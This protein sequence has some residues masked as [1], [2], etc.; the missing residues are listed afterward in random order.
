MS[1]LDVVRR[2]RVHLQEQGRV[3]LRALR[4]EFDLDD[5]AL[6]ELV[7]ELVEVQRVA[8]REGTTVLVH[9]GEPPRPA[10]PPPHLADKIRQAKPAVEGERKQVTVLF[11]DVKGSM[12]LAEQLDPEAWSAIMQRFFAI[13]A[14]GV[15]RFEGFVDKFTGD[16]IMALFGA[17]IA[18]EDHAQ[19]ACWAALHLR[20]EI[21]RYATE[22]KREHGIGFSTR[23]GINSGEV[24]LGTI[25][26]D[27]RMSYT[28]QGHTVGLAQRMEAL[29]SAETCYVSAAT[30]ALVGGY[31]QLEDLGDFRVKGASEPVRVHRLVGAGTATTRLDV[32]RARGLTRF[33]GRDAD[34]ATLEAALAQAQAGHG[35]VV[36]IVAAA[37]TGKSRLCWEFAERCR[38]RGITVNEG[39]A[40][41]HGKN[42]PY[43]PMLQLFRAYYGITDRDDDATVRDKIAGRLLLLDEGFRDV[44]PV[45][46]EF[47]RVPDPERPVPRMDPEA[48][49]RQLFAV[50]RRVIQDRRV[51][52]DRVF[53]LIEDLHW[54][55]P[56]SEALLAQWIDAIGGSSGLLLVNFRPE[57]HAEW[58]QRSYYRQVPLAPLGSDAIRALLAD[59]LGSDPSV[60]GLADD[61]HARTGGNPFFIEEVVQSLIESES[62]QGSR[63]SY[64][65]VTPVERIDVP[66]SVRA[67]LA[68]R[69][70]RLS[71]AEKRVLQTAAVIG[72]E[73]AEP[74]LRKVLAATGRTDGDVGG[75]LAAL[76]AR[77]FLYETALYP[78]AEYAFKHPLTQEVALGSQLQERRRQIHAAVAAAI[79]ATHG[80]KLEEQAALLAHHCAEAGAPLAAARWHARAGRFIGR[81]DF[82][83]A[84]RHWQRARELL[85][86]V[87]DDPESPAL[88]VNACFQI[89]A[90]GLR[91]QIPPDEAHR[92]FEE[93]LAWAVRTGD[94]FHT[95]RFHQA[96]AVLEAGNARLDAAIA[97]ASEWER[98]ART[99][100]DDDRRA[101]ALWPSLEPL[102]VRGDLAAAR[103]NAREQLGWTRDHP[104][105]GLRDWAMSAHA[106]ALW[107]LGRI[108]AYDGSFDRARDYYERGIQVARGVGDVEMEAGCSGA[109][110]NLGFLAGEPDLG[111][112]AGQRAVALCERI[113]GFARVGAYTALGTQLLL[114]G[115][116]ER[117]V[118]TLEFALS[119]CGTGNKQLDQSIRYRLAQACLGAGDASRARALAEAALSQS[120][121]I[122]ARVDA[123]EAAL[124]LSAALRAEV[125]PGA[126]ARIE[127]LLARAERSIAETGAR[128]LIA[129]V[130]AERAALAELRGDVAE[131][132][133]YLR[134]AHASFTRMRA[135]GRARDVAAALER[136]TANP[137]TGGVTWPS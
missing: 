127:E 102:Y 79:E 3:S 44:L 93:G 62:L 98:V 24:V 108:E 96:M 67:L 20:D 50:I 52:A 72:K 78:V 48:K 114:D 121:E 10:S 99:V 63:G 92:V 55:D 15:A 123:V 130:L 23:M 119:A 58:M 109:L 53:A 32:S 68:A 11:A 111:R 51:G 35:Q 43:L 90:I 87:A 106:G 107:V 30:A 5:A 115:Q 135:T 59:L 137:T 75:A 83:E 54:L 91:L 118:E 128:S 6:G 29:A 88:G 8:V 95:G 42:I 129:F 125:G 82:A 77:E 120:L 14:E 105:W 22:V 13:L 71:E 74:V 69:I 65:L 100:A 133:E 117:A 26:D 97:H 60:R 46:F 124:V 126:A 103:A 57:Y 33:V 34:M 70:D 40:L 66:P 19:R 76:T 49:Q 132:M 61:I 85:R 47:F 131:R 12:E 89:L 122:G 39:H 45:V 18:H 17:P 64:R 4:R 113:G 112:T 56:A 2:V 9:V 31:L 84:T 86:A 16:G 73:F 116:V 80:A 110:C 28:A 25:G 104:D 36:G 134:R 101:M 7:D 94:P 37:G 41:A 27:L 38:A 1:F 81:S 136:G 21:A